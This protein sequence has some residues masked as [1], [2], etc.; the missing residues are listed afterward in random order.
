MKDVIGEVVLDHDEHMRPGT[1]MQSLGGLNPSFEG[2]GAQM[3]GFD[4]VVLQKYPE[5]EK[6]NHVHH[7]GNSSG[8]VDGARRSSSATRRWA[9][10][11]A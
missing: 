4:D 10:N 7:G 6:I 11:T 9:R 2:I 1:D 3:P 5:L 8:I